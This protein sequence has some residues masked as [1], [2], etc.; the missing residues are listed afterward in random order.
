[1]LEKVGKSFSVAR[2]H[3]I[4][5]QEKTEN[6]MANSNSLAQSTPYTGFLC[7]ASKVAARNCT[8]R[9]GI[10]AASRNQN[11]KY[12]FSSTSLDF[13]GFVNWLFEHKKTALS[14]ELLARSA[15]YFRFIGIF[16]VPMKNFTFQW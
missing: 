3:P 10:L 13:R 8:L 2:A 5:V 1:M 9:K 16:Y 11:M 15:K 14:S 6:K 4:V 12:F 7:Q